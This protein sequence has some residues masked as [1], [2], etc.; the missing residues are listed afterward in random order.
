MFM[1]VAAE[2]FKIL[3][4]L[5]GLFK[6]LN[7]DS[8]NLWRKNWIEFFLFLFYDDEGMGNTKIEQWG[9]APDS[10]ALVLNCD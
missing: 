8:V 9:S 4:K 1:L 10:P 2:H 6:I 3:H 5:P 7:Q